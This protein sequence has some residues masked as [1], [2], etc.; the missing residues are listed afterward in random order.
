M[1]SR[2]DTDWIDPSSVTHAQIREVERAYW[3]MWTKTRHRAQMARDLTTGKLQAAIP[4]EFIDA[5][6][7]VDNFRVDT[8]FKYTEPLAIK[9]ALAKKSPEIKREPAGIG[10]RAL[11]N[12]TSAE[13]GINAVMSRRDGG[14]RWPAVVD[15][16]LLEGLALHIT[17]PAQAAFD[18]P[19]LM[20][21][22]GKL[23]GKYEDYDSLGAAADDYDDDLERWYRRHP[24]VSYRP[25]SILDSAPILGPG[26]TLEGL[27]VRTVYTESELFKMG[28]RWQESAGLLSPLGSVDGSYGGAGGSPGGIGLPAGSPGCQRILYEL[29]AYHAESGCP[30]VA[31]S[32]QGTPT[33]RDGDDGEGQ[34]SVINL[35]KTYGLDR[36]PVSLEFGQCWETSDPDLKSMPYPAPFHRGWLGVDTMLTGR[37][38]HEWRFGLSGMIEQIDNP[39]LARV[40][41][42]KNVPISLQA[43]PMQVARVFGR[44]VPNVPPPGGEGMQQLAAFI[45]G[46]TEQQTDAD[47][48]GDADQS[49]YAQTVA[50]A[51]AREARYLVSEAARRSYEAAGSFTAEILTGLAKRHDR[52]I[53]IVGNYAVPISRGPAEQSSTRDVL[54]WKETLC[55]DD[56]EVSAIFADAF[57]ENLAKQQQAAEFVDRRLKPRRWFHELTGEQSPEVVEAEILSDQMLMS[58]QGIADTM[59]L[60]AKIQGDR[61]TAA[62]LELMASGQVGPDGV[63]SGLMDGMEGMQTGENLGM[64][65]PGGQPAPGG[66]T[67]IGNPAAASLGG[68]VSA[69]MMSG[70]M[71]Q[72]AAAGAPTP[73][74]NGAAVV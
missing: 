5:V 20:G 2:R 4:Q 58:E 28:F 6:D 12:A 19:K 60:V 61:D 31:Y 32:V 36:L 44:V 35:K 65:P 23:V 26:G 73:D 34:A 68:Q 55:G 56:F 27:L 16:A 62:R 72:S 18:A 15:L 13:Q 40:I 47:V 50:R 7:D 67:G 66:M 11:E 59:A 46:L 24:I 45:L 69:G 37:V 29:W 64:A 52:A 25:V 38:I 63:P 9:Q 22:D 57:G 49:G 21:D 1:A 74:L 53:P 8:P 39:D 71:G 51:Y 30:Y 43:R 48:T 10:P 14:F 70:G 42:E 54:Q 41:L 17:M 33:T 3:P